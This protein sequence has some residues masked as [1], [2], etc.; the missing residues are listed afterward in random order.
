MLSFNSM[1]F[2]SIEQVL[3]LTYIVGFQM[4]GD[5]TSPGIIPLAIKDVFRIIQDVS[6]FICS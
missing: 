2:I 4:Q 6:N 3:L 5:H 1:F